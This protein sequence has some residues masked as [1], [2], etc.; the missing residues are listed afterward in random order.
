M[1]SLLR[2]VDEVIARDRL[3]WKRRASTIDI[4][5]WKQGHHQRVHLERHGDHYRLWS[6]AAGAGYVTRND[7][8]WRALAYRAWRKNSLKE[9][10][11]FSFDRQHRLIGVIEQPAATF[12][13]EELVLYVETLARECDRF[14][15]ILT[16]EDRE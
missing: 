11:G 5:L 13:H 14:E 6:I 2:Q 12:D 9:L 7:S 4:E 1:R 3:P 16:G 8:A 15:F 10:V